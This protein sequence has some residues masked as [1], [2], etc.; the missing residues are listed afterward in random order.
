MLSG[1]AVEVEQRHPDFELLLRRILL[2]LGQNVHQAG[3]GTCVVT[4]GKPDGGFF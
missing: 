1:G 3:L 2:V 4:I